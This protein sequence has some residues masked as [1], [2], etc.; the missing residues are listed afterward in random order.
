MPVEH[1]GFV[2]PLARPHIARGLDREGAKRFEPADVLGR[3]YEGTAKLWVSWNADQRA[4]EA[5]AVTEIVQFPRCRE[6]R[7]WLVGGRNMRAWVYEMRD[8]IE[9][10]ARAHDCR[11]MSG[12]MRR[13][14]VRVGG[15]GW[16]ETGSMFEKE[17]V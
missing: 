14:W 5:A 8:M 7:I 2:W 9:A 16:H 10:Y 15:P 12:A 13:G 3:L 6:L 4:I 11:Y 1:L 17:L